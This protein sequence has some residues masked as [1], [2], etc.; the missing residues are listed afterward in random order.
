MSS[1]RQI[2]RSGAKYPMGFWVLVRKIPRSVDIFS[3][4]KDRGN[5]RLPF[6]SWKTGSRLRRKRRHF[7]SLS[8]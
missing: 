4:K 1:V 3:D 6:F 8:K 2:P 5:T 7:P